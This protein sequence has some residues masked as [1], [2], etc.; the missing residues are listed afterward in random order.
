MSNKYLFS[1]YL[2][3]IITKRKQAITDRNNLIC[4]LQFN[5]EHLFLCSE[6]FL[7]YLR[8]EKLEIQ[9]WTS[10]NDSYDYSPSVSSTDKLI[11]SIYVDLNSLCD[12]KRK[13]HR[14]NAILPMFKHGTKD[15]GGAFAQVHVTIDK[16]KDFNELRVYLLSFKFDQ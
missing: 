14:L 7:W 1:L 13:T 12:R 2:V 16:S 8:E 9:I 15:L 3:P 11:G 6:P 5:K 10:D 4:E